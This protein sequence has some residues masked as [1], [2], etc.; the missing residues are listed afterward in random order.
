MK[1]IS[2]LM[3]A[4]V[5]VILIL[6]MC[7][8]SFV[9]ESAAITAVENQGFSNVEVVDHDWL[10]VGYRGCDAHDTAKFTLTATNPIGQKVEIYACSGFPFKGFTIRSG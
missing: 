7:R 9:S 5:V 6:S 3:Y 2:I 8:G 10:L 1:T 4:F